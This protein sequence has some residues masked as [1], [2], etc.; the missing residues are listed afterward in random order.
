[1]HVKLWMRREGNGAR[2]SQ[3]A[4][5]WD[6]KALESHAVCN[7]WVENRRHK[8]VEGIRRP[9]WYDMWSYGHKQ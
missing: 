6:E 3:D 8:M 9:L 4:E 1:M 2:E 7:R 5:L